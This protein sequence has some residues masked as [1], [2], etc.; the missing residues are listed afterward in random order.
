MNSDLLN[1]TY[2]VLNSSS[3]IITAINNYWGD[4]SGPYHPTTNLNGSGTRVSDLVIYNPWALGSIYESSTYGDWT[5]DF[6][7]YQISTFPST[8]I[9]GG[10]AT[11][12][13]TNYVTADVPSNRGLQCLQLYGIENGCNPSVAFKAL[14]VSS[15]FVLSIDIR[16]A[17]DQLSGC[18]PNRARICLQ[19]DTFSQDS[20]RELVRFDGDGYIYICGIK[21]DIFKE[22]I[23]YV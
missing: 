20:E 2:G 16:N 14:D 8:W 18:N 15:P 13:S 9:K 23:F 19:K 7:T 17:N 4:P 11:D 21:S 12:L 22:E 6:E 5:E 1:S 10:N 3:N